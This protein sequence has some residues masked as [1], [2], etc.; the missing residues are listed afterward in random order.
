[1]QPGQPV[2]HRA[3]GM[4]VVD[5]VREVPYGG[6]YAF[7]YFGDSATRSAVFLSSLF[8]MPAASFTPV[9][10]RES[11]LRRAPE[12]PVHYARVLK[13][14]PS[15][16]QDPTRGMCFEGPNPDTL[17]I[18]HEPVDSTEPVEIPKFLRSTWPGGFRPV[19]DGTTICKNCRDG[20]SSSKPYCPNCGVYP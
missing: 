6:D 9:D 20:F 15:E 12:P 8:A 19:S 17:K 13:S 5:S 7:V 1:V 2:F 14:R 4:G 10:Q 11:L 18:T 16:P 3:Y